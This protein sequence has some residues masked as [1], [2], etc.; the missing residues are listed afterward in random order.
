MQLENA[1]TTRDLGAPAPTLPRLSRGA[2]FWAIAFAFLAVAAFSTA[3]SA[4]YG[5][6][7]QHEHLA[8]IT[9]T[10]VYAVYAAGVTAS[11]LLAGHVSD[12]YGRRVVLIPAIAIAAVAAVV[13]IAWQSLPGL[14]VARVLLRLHLRRR[15]HH[16][17]PRLRRQVLRRRLRREPRRARRQLRVLP[18]VGRHHR[19]EPEPK[20]G[21]ADDARPGHRR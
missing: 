19:A 20:G 5:L 1:L 11:L 9:I 15:S 4:L 3:P 12:S 21:Q 2:G 16:Q 18:R 10:I 13:F 8:P 7:A 17:A 14:L 6:Y